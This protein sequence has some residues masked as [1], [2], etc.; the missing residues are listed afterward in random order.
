MN[1]VEMCCGAGKKFLNELGVSKGLCLFERLLELAM[2]L[3]I[4]LWQIVDSLD[5]QG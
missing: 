2:V 1:V 3:G 4:E 5:L